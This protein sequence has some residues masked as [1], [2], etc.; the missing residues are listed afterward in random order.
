M[1]DNLLSYWEIYVFFAV[2]L[3][4]ILTLSY[5]LDRRRM[6]LRSAYAENKRLKSMLGVPLSEIELVPGAQYVHV[7][8]PEG[9]MFIKRVGTTVSD[10]LIRAVSFD[11]LNAGLI[12]SNTVFSVIESEDGTRILFSKKG[13][14]APAT[15]KTN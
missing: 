12:V 2:T 8:P 14:I 10:P 5:K 15:I 9:T 1:I 13:A 4:I 6:E 3:S 7:E 11:G